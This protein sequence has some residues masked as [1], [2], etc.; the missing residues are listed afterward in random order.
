M[1]DP[2]SPS[3]PDHAYLSSTVD[4]RALADGLDVANR[5]CRSDG[6]APLLGTR[7]NPQLDGESLD[8]WMLRTHSHYW[9]PAGTARMGAADD[10]GVCDADGR[11]HGVDGLRVADASLFPE[12][13][14]AT[15]ALPVVVAG[16]RIAASIP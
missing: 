9:H 13:P 1:D 2:A 12:V 6:L 7:R 8:D 11:V 14:R 4:R 3:T 15:P 5:L 10:R 16:E